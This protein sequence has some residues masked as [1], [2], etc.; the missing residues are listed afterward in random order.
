MQVRKDNAQT[1]K[2]ISMG[3][4]EETAACGGMSLE[5]EYIAAED[6][7][8]NLNIINDFFSAVKLT[9]RQKQRFLLHYCEGLTFRE[10][11][12]KE[13]VHFTSVRDSIEQV[14]QKF[15]EFYLKRK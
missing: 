5:D 7:K 4:L 10:A 8:R 11:A 13:G 14:T 1:K 15:R 9:E 3:E 2:N 12:Q 6:R